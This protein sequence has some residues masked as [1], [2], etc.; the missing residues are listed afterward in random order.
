MFKLNSKRIL[1]TTCFML[2]CYCLAAPNN[3]NKPWIE[4]GTTKFHSANNEVAIKLDPPQHYDQIKFQMDSKIR[5]VSANLVTTDN[6]TGQ[7]INYSSTSPTMESKIKT[8]RKN[9]GP[10][11]KVIIKY[12]NPGKNKGVIKLFGRSL[13]EIA[14]STQSKKN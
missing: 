8:L 6:Q 12:K 14:Q 13:D 5:L 7:K 2:S 10:I 1:A 4:A 11:K 3:M 9:L